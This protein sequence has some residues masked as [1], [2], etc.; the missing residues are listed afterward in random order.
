M[1]RAYKCRIFKAS[2]KVQFLCESLLVSE[3]GPRWVDN[4]IGSWMGATV[5]SSRGNALV[6]HFDFHV[7]CFIVNANVSNDR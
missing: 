2:L 5:A 1:G 6:G 3:E 4:R 7:P